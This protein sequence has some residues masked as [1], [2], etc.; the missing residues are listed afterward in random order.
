A[1]REDR[2]PIT[3][4]ISQL[5]YGLAAVGSVSIGASLCILLMAVQISAMAVSTYVLKQKTSF[6]GV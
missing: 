4:F 3:F 5:V 2:Q 1:L 6:L